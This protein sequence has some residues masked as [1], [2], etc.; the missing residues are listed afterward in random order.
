MSPIDDVSERLKWVRLNRI[1]GRPGTHKLAPMLAAIGV[2]ASSASISRYERPASK[3]GRVPSADYIIGI[4]KLGNA[5]P[6]WVLFGVGSRDLRTGEADSEVREL[7]SE[8]KAFIEAS[9]VKY[10][11]ATSGESAGHGSVVDAAELRG[12]LQHA[13]ELLD[14]LRRAGASPNRV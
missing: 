5:D 2:E 9:E 4:C 3:G 1:P 12:V 6:L 13:E 14:R 10:L 8:L 7:L 11:G